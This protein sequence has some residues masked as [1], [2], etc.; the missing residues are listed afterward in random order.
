MSTKVWKDISEDA[1]E[2]VKQM[3]T[4]DPTQRI[5]AKDALRHKWFECAPST[6]IN[7]DLMKE[8]LKNLLTFNAV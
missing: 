4:K 1:K 2:L 7:I 8:S 5:S 3:L 6:A